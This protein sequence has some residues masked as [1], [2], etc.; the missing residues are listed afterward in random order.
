MSRTPAPR[1]RYNQL[2]GTSLDRLAGI[3]DGIFA[4]G[5]TLLVLNLGVPELRSVSDGNLVQAL[6]GLG[7]K[8]LV[9]ILSFMTLGIFWVGQ[10][11]QLSQLIRSDRHF[12][13][14]QLGFLFTVTVVPFSTALLARYPTVHVALIEYWLN[15][16]LLGF[17]LL[18]SA[19]YAHRAGLF[20][21]SA[22]AEVLF[23]IRGRIWIAQ[24]L[25]AVAVALGFVF[26]TTWVSIALIV[27]IQLNYVLAPRI[28]ILDRF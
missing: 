12:S 14:I 15:I 16:A 25:Y 5:M 8:A 3:S 13:W 7:P 11:T 17:S 26:Q 1:R 21:E 19:E 24:G 28:P 20:D 23:R 18:G 27:L 9:Y 2:A 10:G 4:V 22:A 6:A